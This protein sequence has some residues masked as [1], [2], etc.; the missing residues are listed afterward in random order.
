MLLILI[1]NVK[2]LFNRLSE[3]A[4]IEELRVKESLSLSK[5]CHKDLKIKNE[6]GRVIFLKVVSFSPIKNATQ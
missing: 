6:S 3:I 4:F 1:L 5:V 2:L